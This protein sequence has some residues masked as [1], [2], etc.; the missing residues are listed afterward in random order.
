[1]STDSILKSSPTS[2]KIDNNSGS[3]LSKIRHLIENF[4]VGELYELTA[5][6]GQRERDNYEETD[7]ISVMPPEIVIRPNLPIPRWHYNLE[8][9][10]C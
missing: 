8:H 3:N 6:E 9:C 1:M 4:N 5:N 7:N 2:R 10:N